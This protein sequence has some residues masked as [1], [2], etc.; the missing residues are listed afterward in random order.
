MVW[1]AARLLSTACAAAAP[2][3]APPAHITTM[4]AYGFNASAQAGWCSWGKS[5]NLSAL[6]EGFEQHG[7]PGLYRIDC[8]GCQGL[9]KGGGVHP[10]DPGPSPS[11][12]PSLSLSLSD[13][14]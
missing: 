2:P 12:P 8:V 1:A 6:V 14:V 3:A 11:L 7:L 5:F 10:P 9:E 13:S 4:T